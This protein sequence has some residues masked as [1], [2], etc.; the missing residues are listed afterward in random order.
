LLPADIFK[1]ANTT[2]DGTRYSRALSLVTT[3]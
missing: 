3:G 2:A 1:G